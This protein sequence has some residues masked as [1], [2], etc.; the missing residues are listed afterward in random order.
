LSDTF[1][2]AILAAEIAPGGMKA[3]ALSGR[4]LVICNCEGTFH[5]L[6]RRCGHMNAPLEKGTL[7]GSILTCAMHC[8]RFDVATGEALAGPVPPHLGDEPVP[9]RMGAYLQNVGMLMRDIRT[10]AIRKYNVKTEGGWVWVDLHS[11]EP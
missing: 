10:E 4:E 1:V 9:P 7:D 6:D 11:E 5:A 2:K 3:V 8:A